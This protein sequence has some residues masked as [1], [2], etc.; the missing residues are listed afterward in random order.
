MKMT[1][2]ATEFSSLLFRRCADAGCECSH[3]TSVLF[4]EQM[5]SRLL[6]ICDERSK[7]KS[8]EKISETDSRLSREDGIRFVYFYFVMVCD[9][10]T[11]CE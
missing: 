6:I 11:E 9:G 10:R 7:M 1:S 3:L 2:S 4:Q 5:P 8:Q